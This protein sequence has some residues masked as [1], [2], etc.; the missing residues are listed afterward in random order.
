MPYPVCVSCLIEY[1]VARVG[2][3]VL[4]L[5]GNGEPCQLWSGDVLECPA[6]GNQ[7]I[8]RWGDHAYAAAYQ[9]DFADCVAT[10]KQVGCI[11]VA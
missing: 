5:D 10:A 4:F 3:N 2:V 9:E 6:C 11:T 7:V 1:R 8:F